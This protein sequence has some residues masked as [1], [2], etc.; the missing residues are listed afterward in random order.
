[1]ILGM[2]LATFTQLHVIISLI[3]IVSGLLAAAGM[4]SARRM[5][6]TTAL[7]LFM[8][9]AT[10]VTGFMFDTPVEAPRVI[11]SLDPPKVIGLISLI[12]LG[13]A[14]LALYG[15]KLASGWRGTYVVCAAI[16]LYLNCFV[17][18][19]QSFQKISFVHALAPTQKEPPFAVAQGVLLIVFIGLGVA[20]F[21]KFR[22]MMQA[23]TPA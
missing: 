13:L 15:Y 20:A 18:V 4:L 2:S 17:L 12:V 23:P 5:P 22:P 3:G 8:T 6:G 14:L 19:V 10:S 7:F 16:A 1:M 9:V 21:R 11:G